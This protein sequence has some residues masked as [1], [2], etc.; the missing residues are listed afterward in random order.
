[1]G[2]F[3]NKHYKSVILQT[4]SPFRINQIG[5]CSLCLPGTAL[6]VDRMCPELSRPATFMAG[7]VVFPHSLQMNVET[8]HDVKTLALPIQ[9][10]VWNSCSSHWIHRITSIT[11]SARFNV[12]NYS[13]SRKDTHGFSHCIVLQFRYIVVCLAHFYTS[14]E[15]CLENIYSSSFLKQARILSTTKN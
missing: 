5:A 7:F 13:A 11:H 4:I 1:M 15:I 6:L 9:I 10:S 12:L 14:F 8:R 2:T 3:K